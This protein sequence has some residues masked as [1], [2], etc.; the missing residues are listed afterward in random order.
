MSMQLRMQ[1]MKLIEKQKM[2]TIRR[3]VEQYVQIGGAPRFIHDLDEID[4][5]IEKVKYLKSKGCLERQQ[6]FEYQELCLVEVELE[7]EEQERLREIEEKSV[8][9]EIEDFHLINSDIN[10]LS[11]VEFEKVC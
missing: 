4:A 5:C 10:T 7:R 11:G 2:D 8:Q 3:K 1:L 9:Q 6:E